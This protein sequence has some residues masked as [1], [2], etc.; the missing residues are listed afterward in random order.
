MNQ[1]KGW[2][3]VEDF[4]PSLNNLIS[5]L[6]RDNFP[7]A[8]LRNLHLLGFSQGAALAFSFAMIYP[9][10]VQTIG[11]L[12]GFLPEDAEKWLSSH[13]LH[14]KPIFIAHGAQDDLVPVSKARNSVGLLEKTGAE[15]VY[16]E[17]D[18][19]HKLS[20]SCFRSMEAFYKK[21]F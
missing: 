7:I 6:T 20:A 12:S 10:F 18:V 13:A 5:L 11:S 8:D 3:N 16:C 21:Y 2:P 19:G 4:R 9:D 15:V 1:Q 14:G 17:D